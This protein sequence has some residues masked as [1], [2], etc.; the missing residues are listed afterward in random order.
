MSDQSI[1]SSRD[2]TVDLFAIIEL[3]PNISSILRHVFALSVFFESVDDQINDPAAC[4]TGCLICF[5]LLSVSE[6]C[7]ASCMTSFCFE[8]FSDLLNI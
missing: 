5:R 8:S 1:R 2:K 6:T 4:D 3:L 7:Q